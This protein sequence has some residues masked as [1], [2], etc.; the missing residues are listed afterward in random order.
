MQETLTVNRADVYAELASS[1]AYTGVKR[2][3]DPAAQDDE[4][5]DRIAT[6]DEDKEQLQR[7]W[8]EARTEVAQALIRFIITEEMDETTGYYRLTLELPSSFDETMLPSMQLSLFSYFVQSIA[9]RWFALASNKGD[10]EAYAAGAKAY[11]DDVR[12]KAFYKR[13]P[14]RPTYND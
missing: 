9:A 13:R 10:V 2:S 14:T 11:L 12:Q 4:A 8:D 5:L 6:I 7:F 1:T 3:K